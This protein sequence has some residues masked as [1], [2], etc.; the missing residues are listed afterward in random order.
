MKLLKFYADWCAPCK[1]MTPVL[2]G[3]LQGYPNIELQEVNAG[4]D[5]DTVVK[6]GV[7]SVPTLILTDDEGNVLREHKGYSATPVAN[8]QLKG[9]LVGA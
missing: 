3:M 4:I 1:A 8:D 2:Q 9:F 5:K 7:R 6:Y